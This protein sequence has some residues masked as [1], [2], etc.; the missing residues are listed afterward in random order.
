MKIKRTAALILAAVMILMLTSCGIGSNKGSVYWLNFKPELDDTLQTLAQQYTQETGVNVTVKTVE[1][2]TYQQ[3][4]R[5]EM[6]S[7]NP[8]TLFVITDQHSADEW[9]NY[10]LDLTETDI[11]KQQST[12]AYNF[13]TEEGAIIAIPYCLECFGIAVNP[14]LIEKVGYT[15]DDL[16]D[17]ETLKFVAEA[18]HE[19][20]GWLGFDAFCSPDLDA[21]SSWRI[22]GHLANI[23]YYYELRD[24]GS[25]PD[26]PASL[27]GKYMTNFKNLYDLCVNN[28]VS[29][30][31]T[32][33]AGGHHPGEEFTSGK[34]AFFLT[35][36]WDY[37][38]LSQAIPNVTMIP[39]YCGVEGEEKAALN[40]GSENYWAVNSMVDTTDQRATIAFMKW[41]V[42]DPDASGAL[43]EQ[44]GNLPFK[45]STKAENGFLMKQSEYTKSGCY[46]MEWAMSYQPNVEVYRGNLAE[47]LKTY[48]ADQSDAN[49]EKVKEAMIDGWAQQYAAVHNN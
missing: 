11:Q 13:T 43:T 28:S 27:T 33:A 34:A 46:K 2:G 19:N 36:S 38:K 26:C 44:V 15:V 32:L 7:D 39:Y 5:E 1:S 47:A 17:F 42:T 12:T 22:T 30:P 16:K 45:S 40:S 23:E 14:G 18:I 48:N 49:W 4:L 29:D 6:A 10:A 41:L 8:P 20:S 24:A 9:K 3:T 37:S 21:E 25:W 31:K 35:G